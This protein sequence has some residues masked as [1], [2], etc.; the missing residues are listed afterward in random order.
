MQNYT[1]LNSNSNY[2]SRRSSSNK[3]WNRNQNTTRYKSEIKLG[4]VTH[5]VFIALV[6][7]VLGLIYLTQAAKITNYDYE[8]Q[9]IDAEISELMSKKEDLEIENAK[10]TA[11]NTIADSEV[12]NTMTEPASTGFVNN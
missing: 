2:A 1:R 7:T 5:T 12:A 10:L 3:G 6:V 8:A 11:L 4:P 9:A